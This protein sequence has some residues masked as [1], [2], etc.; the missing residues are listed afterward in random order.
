[1]VAGADP[2]AALPWFLAAAY[3]NGMVFEVG[4]KLRAPQ[5]EEP[6][7]ETYSALWGTR[8]AALLWFCALALAGVFTVIA[9]TSVGAT[10]PAAL[11]AGASIAATLWVA[12][13]FAQSPTSTGSKII[14]WYSAAW[15]LAA[16]LIFGLF[17]GT[18]SR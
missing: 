9:A 15:L 18:G 11:I 12:L 10:Q 17:A 6:G 3:A 5:D 1:L 13:R 16:Y 14:R 8:R 2:P 4:R 7:V